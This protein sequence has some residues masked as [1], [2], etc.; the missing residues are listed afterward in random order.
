MQAR[1]K[2]IATNRLVAQLKDGT[3]ARSETHPD[4]DVT[5]DI[6]DMELTPGQYYKI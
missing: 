3:F 1:I 5:F 4:Y 6:S 2:T